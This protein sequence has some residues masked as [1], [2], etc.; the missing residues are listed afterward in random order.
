[1]Y[2]R[3]ILFGKYFS[4]GLGGGKPPAPHGINVYQGAFPHPDPKIYISKNFIGAYISALLEGGYYR[5]FVNI[6]RRCAPIAAALGHNCKVGLFPGLRH[7]TIAIHTLTA[8]W[9]C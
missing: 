3:L 7:A 5:I 8:H 1:M 9:F 2:A 4:P 6:G